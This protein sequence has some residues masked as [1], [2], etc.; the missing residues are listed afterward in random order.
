[1]VFIWKSW[2]LFFCLFWVS[3]CLLLCFFF[4]LRTWALLL[5]LFLK[6]VGKLGV[7]IIPELWCPVMLF[8]LLWV[9]GIL[10][11]RCN[12][13][14][15]VFGLHLYSGLS[16]LQIVGYCHVS[17]SQSFIHNLYPFTL[18]V[19]VTPVPSQIP[20]LKYPLAV[21]ELLSLASFCLC[22]Q[23]AQEWCSCVTAYDTQQVTQTFCQAQNFFCV[24]QL[25][26]F[27]KWVSV[28]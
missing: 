19:F 9:A 28:F 6:S 15:P 21:V 20:L 13:S 17:I 27:F 8:I 3:F 25:C 23:S 2:W 1:M 5:F 18:P 11:K 4:L 7:E 14:Q 10:E 12:L 16:V 22:R 26:S 24:P